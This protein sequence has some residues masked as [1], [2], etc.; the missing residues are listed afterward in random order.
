[1]C[2][3]VCHEQIEVEDKPPTHEEEVEMNRK[4]QSS[5]KFKAWLAA[6]DARVIR[7]FVQGP[8]APKPRRPPRTRTGRSDTV[9][10]SPLHTALDSSGDD[11][12]GASHSQVE[13]TVHDGNRRQRTS[14]APAPGS[15]A[16]L[17]PRVTQLGG[18]GGRR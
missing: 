18:Q 16:A 8:L 15:P 4:A 2:S 12:L 6:F 3:L 17:P 11:D 14:S 9:H 5:S 13:L 1:M 10:E 7:R